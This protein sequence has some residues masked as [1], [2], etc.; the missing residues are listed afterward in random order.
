MVISKSNHGEA[1][2]T[3]I[4]FLSD[5]QRNDHRVK[6]FLDKLQIVVGEHYCV[7]YKRYIEDG[8]YDFG[9][10]PEQFATREQAEKY[11]EEQGAS[12][13][14]DDEREV[15]VNSDDHTES[16]DDYVVDDEGWYL[17]KEN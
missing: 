3:L 16:F 7:G 2:N 8:M 17:W 15:C 13:Y 1:V 6:D 5:E 12:F 14:Y 9:S 10:D 11:L 4:S